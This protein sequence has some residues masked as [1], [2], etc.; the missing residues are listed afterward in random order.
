MR[1]RW[2]AAGETEGV[3]VGQYYSGFT[4]SV[5]FADSSPARGKPGFTA[6]KNKKRPV[7]NKETK[8]EHS[9]VPL[10]L[11][12]KTPT[13]QGSPDNGGVPGVL[14]GSFS[15]LLRGDIR[16]PLPSALHQ[17]GGSLS[18]SGCGYL[19]SS[20]LFSSILSYLIRFRF[21]CQGKKWAVRRKIKVNLTFCPFLFLSACDILHCD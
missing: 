21:P 16:R 2:I 12:A 11:P 7:S 13:T 5:S 3:I 1:G 8:R 17:Y 18:V 15:P 6:Q 10:L 14:T 19:S 9:A 20:A 4:P